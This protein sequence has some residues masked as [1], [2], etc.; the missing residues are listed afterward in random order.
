[1]AAVAVVAAVAVLGKAQRRRPP[2][3]CRVPQSAQS[4]PY[5]HKEYSDPADTSAA[6][7][8]EGPHYDDD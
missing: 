3:G 7:D 8:E 2:S 5:V 4:W 6:D 1:M